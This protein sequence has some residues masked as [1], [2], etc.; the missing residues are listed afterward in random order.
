MKTLKIARAII[1]FLLTNRACRICL[2]KTLL[3]ILR[4]ITNFLVTYWFCFYF[5][6]CLYIPAFKDDYDLCNRLDQYA[7]DWSREEEKLCNLL[8]MLPPLSLCTY[9]ACFSVFVN[10]LTYVDNKSCQWIEEWVMG[11]GG[12]GQAV[13]ENTSIFYVWPS[14]ASWKISINCK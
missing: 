6:I 13:V 1:Y 10:W 4:V 12:M 3:K 11:N 8:R 9:A 2:I 7:I 5:V 14:H